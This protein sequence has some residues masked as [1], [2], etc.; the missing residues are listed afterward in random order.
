MGL[1]SAAMLLPVL[2]ALILGSGTS[3]PV[4]DAS[5]KCNDSVISSEDA[6][7]KLKAEFTI[8]LCCL[9]SQAAACKSTGF[10][11]STNVLA[12]MNDF[13]ATADASSSCGQQTFDDASG[14]L[15]RTAAKYVTETG[16][17]KCSPTLANSAVSG[18]C[19]ASVTQE[20]GKYLYRGESLSCDCGK[21]YTLFDSMN[22]TESNRVMEADA[23]TW[24][25]LG[26][27]PKPELKTT[28]SNAKYWKRNSMTFKIRDIVP[29]IVPDLK[30]PNGICRA[31]A[32]DNENRAYQGLHFGCK[33]NWY[34]EYTM[35]TLPPYA[36]GSSTVTSWQDYVK[37]HRRRRGRRR[38]DRR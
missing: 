27:C 6:G 9:G 31:A 32:S 12:T 5:Y 34:G 20:E 8:Q 11:G 7:C 13:Q 10:C 30:N 3:T 29:G 21:G 19:P 17:A 33:S 26:Q 15:Y 37:G 2:L 16:R 24:L 23:F 4:C 35:D 38:D 25:R 28:A 22:P 14:V 36:L 1:Q 18:R